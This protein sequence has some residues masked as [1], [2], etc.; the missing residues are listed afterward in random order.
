MGVLEFNACRHDCEP[1]GSFC[2]MAIAIVFRS[3]RDGF[4]A[5]NAA[6][7]TLEA[8]RGGDPL[9]R[10]LRLDRRPEEYGLS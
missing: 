1:S 9:S 8:L 5:G 10:P 7:G 3:A 6:V 2:A 4:V